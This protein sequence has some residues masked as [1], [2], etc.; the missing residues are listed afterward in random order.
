MSWIEYRLWSIQ[1]RALLWPQAEEFAKE[2]EIHMKDH[3]WFNDSLYFEPKSTGEG[4]TFL[5]G[6]IYDDHLEDEYFVVKL[7]LF[8][9][10]LHKDLAI[11]IQDSDGEFL[12]YEGADFI[13]K[14]ITPS[15]QANRVFLHK[16]QSTSFQKLSKHLLSKL[17]YKL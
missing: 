10:N 13:P 16:E 17:L 15:C 5:Y 4:I 12:L 2:L 14:W 7:L 9:S 1:D 11:Q 3:L 6:K 8:L